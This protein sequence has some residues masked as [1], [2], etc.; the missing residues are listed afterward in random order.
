MSIDQLVGR[1]VCSAQEEFL[2]ELVG[3]FP[4]R[5]GP[6]QTPSYANS[7]DDVCCHLEGNLGEYESSVLCRIVY[8]L[9]LAQ[10]Y[11]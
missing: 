8:R 10:V 11:K 4:A 6:D 2:D 7:R 9:E 3:R 5:T 1:W